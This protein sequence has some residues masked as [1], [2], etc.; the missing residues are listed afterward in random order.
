[1]DERP[2]IGYAQRCADHDVPCVEWRNGDA[3][4]KERLSVFLCDGSPATV[5]ASFHEQTGVDGM[6]QAVWFDDCDT[7]VCGCAV[8]RAPAR[9]DLPPRDAVVLVY[10]HELLMDHFMKSG[11]T[12]EEAVEWISF[13]M[14]GAW[15]GDNTPFVLH[16][17]E[18]IP[19]AED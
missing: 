4:E 3:V 14:E 10:S 2:I 13:N 18:L 1:M 12:D 15:V 17:S 5:L 8:R 9:E 11:M 19:V 16:R 6:A 7:A